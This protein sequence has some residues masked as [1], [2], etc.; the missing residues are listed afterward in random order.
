MFYML[1]WELITWEIYVHLKFT[2]IH[3][4]IYIVTSKMNIFFILK[5]SN[6]ILYFYDHCFLYPA[7]KICQPQISYIYIIYIY[8]IKKTL[9][10]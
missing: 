7:P 10:L 3:E 5:N 9:I 6:I 8:N 1:I 4:F 2:E